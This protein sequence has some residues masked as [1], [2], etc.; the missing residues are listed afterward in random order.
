MFGK[1]F[2]K[3]YVCYY[4]DIIY[5]CVYVIICMLFD[6]FFLKCGLLWYLFVECCMYLDN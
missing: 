6:K 5:N 2:I 3:W 1:K 4:I